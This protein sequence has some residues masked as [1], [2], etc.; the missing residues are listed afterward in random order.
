MRA[1][2][3]EKEGMFGSFIL[4]KAFNQANLVEY[5]MSVLRRKCDRMRYH[6]D[7]VPSVGDPYVA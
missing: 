2:V 1:R 3:V 5:Y 6:I 7:K 4:K